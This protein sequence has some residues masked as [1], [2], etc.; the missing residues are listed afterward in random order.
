MVASDKLTLT[1]TVSETTAEIKWMKNGVSVSPRGEINQNGYKSTLVIKGVETDDSGFYSCEAHNQA[2]SMMSSAVEIRV[3]G[4][5]A[6]A[7]VLVS[8]VTVNKC[9]LL[10]V[11]LYINKTST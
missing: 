3:R 6:S 4:K 10:Y 8:F 1:C 5:L 2:G 9:G 11:N 7:V